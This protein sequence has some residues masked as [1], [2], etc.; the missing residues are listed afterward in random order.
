[1]GD[2]W[3]SDDRLHIV[4][5]YIQAARRARKAK[6]CH[7]DAIGYWRWKAVH[8]LAHIAGVRKTRAA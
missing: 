1:M 6:N 5:S 2:L 4:W 7:P 3:I 8:Y